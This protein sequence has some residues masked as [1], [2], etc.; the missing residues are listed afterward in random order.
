MDST[1][2]ILEE[3]NGV[4]F[5]P[6]SLRRLRCKEEEKSDIATWRD[7]TFRRCHPAVIWR[8]LDLATI[9]HWI[10]VE[11][12]PVSRSSDQPVA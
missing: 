6:V 11:K 4:G 9:P 2:A 3:S 7:L 1:G 5:P 12:I 8:A 10:R